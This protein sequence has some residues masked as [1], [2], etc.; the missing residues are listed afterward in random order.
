[1]IVK[2]IWEGPKTLD[3]WLIRLDLVTRDYQHLKMPDFI[4]AVVLRNRGGLVIT[5]GNAYFYCRNSF[6][7]ND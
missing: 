6:D 5:L 3:E 7:D 2:T 1:M 4:G